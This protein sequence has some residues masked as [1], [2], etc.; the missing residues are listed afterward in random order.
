MGPGAVATLRDLT[1]GEFLLVVVLASALSMG[2]FW[3]ASK[4]GSRHPTAWGVATFLF[5]G[6][7]IP[8]YVISVILAN[9]RS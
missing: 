9:R 2:V 7:A 4:R 6:I 3:H 1:L 8:A 5:A